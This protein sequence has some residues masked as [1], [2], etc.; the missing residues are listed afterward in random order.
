MLEVNDLRAGYGDKEI[1]HG[2]SFDIPRGQF[3]CVIGANGC[4]KS[5]LLKNMLGLV[6]P[7]GGEVR[8]E[9]ADIASMDEKERARHF[10]YIPQAHTPPFPFKVSDVVILGRTPYLTGIATNVSA[11][12]QIVAYRA[13]QQLSIEHLADKIYTELSGGQQQLVLVAR[14]LAQ[15]PDL[16]VM[17]EPTASLDFG[18]Q[19]LVLSCVY[20]LSR[21]GMSVLMVTHDPGHALSCADRVIMMEAGRVIGDGTPEQ[22]ITTE[23][24]RRIYGTESYVVDVALADGEMAR[25]CVPMIRT[26]GRGAAEC[27]GQAGSRIGPASADGAGRAGTYDQ[28][29]SPA[30]Q[31]GQGEE[32]SQS[33]ESD[34]RPRGDSSPSAGSDER[35]LPRGL[36]EGEDR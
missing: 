36:S 17:D 3:V 7:L 13:M 2:V 6:K 20:E 9:G 19:Q 15:Q 29:S 14:A 12:D 21:M 35:G 4:G 10:A 25:V 24:L 8:I 18:N 31:P 1:V 30:R 22:V 11:H 26:D 27:G 33:D 23:N 5:T 28:G 34:E 16:L 32:S